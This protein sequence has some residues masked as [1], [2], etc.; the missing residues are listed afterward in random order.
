MVRLSAEASPLSEGM[1]LRALGRLGPRSDDALSAIAARGDRGAFGAVYERHHQALYRYCHSIVGHHED[2]FDAVHN[3]MLKAWEALLGGG[4]NAPLRPWLFRVAHNE[5]ITVLRRRRLHGE[6]D[7]VHT[8]APQPV[9]ETLDTRERLARLRADLKAMPERQRSAL[10]LRELCGLG[11]DEIAAVLDVSP[12]TARQTIYEARVALHEAEAGR[13]LACAIVRR[14]LSDGD[15]RVRRGRKMRSHLRGCRD[16]ASFDEALRR[17]PSEL[18]A[19]TPLV[20]GVTVAQLLSRLLCAQGA[21]GGGAAA[22]GGAVTTGIAGAG[23]AISQA[24]SVIAATLTVG[25]VVAAGVGGVIPIQHAA[26]PPSAAATAAASAGGQGRLGPELATKPIALPHGWRTRPLVGRTPSTSVRTPS[27]V[28]PS[29]S[30]GAGPSSAPAAPTVAP[31]PDAA[32]HPGHAGPPGAPA[33]AATTM[34]PAESGAPTGGDAGSPRAPT[35][36]AGTTAPA[37]DGGRHAGSPGAQGPPVTTVRP[38]PN[39]AGAG[40]PRQPGAQMPA[41]SGEP[42]PAAA[43]VAT[44]PKPRVDP[45]SRAHPVGNQPGAS[46]AEPTG[47]AASPVPVPAAPPRADRAATAPPGAATP[48][49]PS[50]NARAKPPDPQGAAAPSGAARSDPPAA[51]PA[52]ARHPAAA[53]SGA[54]PPAADPIGPPQNIGAFPPVSHGPTREPAAAGAAARSAGASSMPAQ[55]PPGT[56]VSPA[57]VPPAADSAPPRGARGH[58]DQSARSSEPPSVRPPSGLRDAAPP[59]G[60]SLRAPAGRPSAD[61]AGASVTRSPS[62]SS[63][64]QL[65]GA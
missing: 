38:A 21:S 22:V 52:N 27:G 65:P 55:P 49:P 10:L 47:P 33:P 37:A 28:A 51:A 17:R 48:A 14:T 7:D 2:A 59:A 42:A 54:P 32:G 11:H 19:L 56:D 57:P 61:A 36:P 9:E 53:A 44:P 39:G 12:A 23:S 15:G 18:A 8:A 40:R 45:S 1:S 41:A 46:R 60:E 4:P 30:G 6:L 50:P 3:T 16:C 29:A 58:A 20:P 62:Q 63:A 25:T 31:A 43:S 24:A 34:R 26:P 5:A 13:A 64:G 35:A